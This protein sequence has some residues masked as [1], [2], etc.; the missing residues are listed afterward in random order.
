MLVL[1]GLLP[2]QLPVLG[3]CTGVDSCHD[4]A[5]VQFGASARTMDWA[6]LLTSGLSRSRAVL[7]LT[8]A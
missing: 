1:L 2:Q 6:S 7:R 5:G 4:T 8:E 3:A